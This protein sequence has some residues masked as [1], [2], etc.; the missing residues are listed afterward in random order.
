MAA[1]G[2]VKPEV[3]VASVEAATATAVSEPIIGNQRRGDKLAGRVI[4]P[5]TVPGAMMPRAAANGCCRA[6]AA[7]WL[8]SSGTRRM[9][10]FV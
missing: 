10:T 6:S 9:P 1:M 7:H 5:S 3:S 8:Q 4:L 2:C